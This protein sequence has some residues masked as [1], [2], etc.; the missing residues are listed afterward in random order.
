VFRLAGPI[1]I[2]FSNVSWC[3]KVWQTWMKCYHGTGSQDLESTRKT[4]SGLLGTAP[5]LPGNDRH[6][7]M[8]FCCIHCPTPLDAG[9]K[10]LDGG[11]LRSV[12][13]HL[14]EQALFTS[15]SIAYSSHPI[16]AKHVSV[17]NLPRQ[18]QVVLQI[19]QFPGQLID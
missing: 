19:R 5:L 8:V 16:Y 12:P 9:D 18:I 7:I 11:V 13:G 15:P 6:N 17:P 3:V 1:K 2:G 10:K 4:V 14:G